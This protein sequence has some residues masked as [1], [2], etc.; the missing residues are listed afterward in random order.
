[1][2][3]CICHKNAPQYEG[4]IIKNHTYYLFNIM[5]NIKNFNQSLSGIDKLSSKSANINI[6]HVEYMSMKILDN[7]NIDGANCLYLIFN[8][9]VHGY[10]IEENNEELLIFAFTCNSKEVF[11]KYTKLWGEIKNQI[12]II[13]GGKPI[14][15][16]KDFLKIR[17]K[18]DDDLP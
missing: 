10:I 6:Y 9:A 15:C 4:N 5:T 13:N 11:K 16:K 1:M 2:N 8:N 12:G 17:F 18:S 14:E 3:V 7:V